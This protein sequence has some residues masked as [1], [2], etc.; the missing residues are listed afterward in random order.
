MAARPVADTFLTPV[1]AI[2]PD[3]AEAYELT[4]AVVAAAHGHP[5]LLLDGASARDQTPSPVAP[6]P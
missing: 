3:K 5:S 4:L 2:R 1:R 6:R